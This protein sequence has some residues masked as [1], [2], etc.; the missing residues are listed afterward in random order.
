L[1]K[2]EIFFEYVSYFS[3]YA[4]HLPFQSNNRQVLI[5]QFSQLTASLKV[6]RS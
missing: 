4:I 1:I 5:S 3:E 2:P 6:A